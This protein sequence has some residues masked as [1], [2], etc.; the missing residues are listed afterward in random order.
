LVDE[1]NQFLDAHRLAKMPIDT[2]LEGKAFIASAPVPGQRGNRHGPHMRI[3]AQL[4]RQFITVHYRQIDIQKHHVRT[5][6]SRRQQRR[7]PVI[8]SAHRMA[9]VFQQFRQNVD[10]H[11]VIIHDQNALA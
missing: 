1:G 9:H 5:A 4:A 6:L 11:G 8:G 10:H 2:R 7:L 3:L